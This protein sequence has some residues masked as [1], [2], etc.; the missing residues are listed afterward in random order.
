MAEGTSSFHPRKRIFCNK[1]RNETT[2]N[3]KG[4]SSQPFYEDD[5]IAGPLYVETQVH[6]F[7]ICAGCGTGTLQKFTTHDGYIEEGTG[8]QLRTSGS[9]LYYPRRTKYDAI[10]KPFK[11]IPER[12]NRMY[13]ETIR[14]FNEKLYLLCAAGLRSLVEGICDERGIKSG[15]LAARIEAMKEI[16][17]EDIVEK[18]HGFNAI[19]IDAVHYLT[20]YT[21][22]E[23]LPAIEGVEVLLSFLLE[24]EDKVGHLPPDAKRKRADGKVI[25]MKDRKDRD[26]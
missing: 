16:L 8:Y 2:H 15:T 3:L 22:E 4:E 20:P 17:P 9:G 10:E 25:K 24:F 18:I 23:L 1:C 5:P 19:G 6:L 12:L 26:K 11:K 21:R 7:W 14:A 13:R